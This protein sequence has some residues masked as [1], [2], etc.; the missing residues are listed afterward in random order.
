MRVSEVQP[1]RRRS[2]PTQKT[3]SF[4]KRT[5]PGE[6][7]ELK[8]PWILSVA[9]PLLTLL[10]VAVTLWLGIWNHHFEE[11]KLQGTLCSNAK[12]F[13]LLVDPDP[14]QRLRGQGLLSA[15]GF[16]PQYIAGIT[17][18]IA[19]HDESPPVRSN[20]AT[21]LRKLAQDDAADVR[22][23][24]RKGLADY[25][26]SSELRNK[27]LLQTLDDAAAF[28]STHSPEGR[29]QAW[30]C[31]TQVLEQLS[32]ESKSAM[33]AAAIGDAERAAKEGFVDRAVNILSGMFRPYLE[34]R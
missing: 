29:E 12:L 1:P 7:H 2:S 20:A 8:L 11:Q 21:T 5:G 32:V 31:F 22:N 24:A 15:C 16:D 27:G 26:V 9:G 13:D 10:G 6:T 17:G 33:G 3:E 18:A 34:N 4:E 19:L 14:N 25:M 30:K 23:V 28:A